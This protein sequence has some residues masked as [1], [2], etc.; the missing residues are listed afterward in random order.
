MLLYLKKSYPLTPQIFLV[1]VY[2][3]ASHR[4]RSIV[5]LMTT[6]IIQ[7]ILYSVL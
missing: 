7:P 6:V 4:I 3:D 1:H 5:A 2:Q